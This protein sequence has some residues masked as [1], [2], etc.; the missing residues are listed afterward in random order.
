MQSGSSVNSVARTQEWAVAYHGTDHC[1][2]PSILSTGL[3]PGS[4]QVYRREVGTGVYVSP[5]MRHAAAYSTAT[6][7]RHN[8]EPQ[9]PVAASTVA[10]RKVGILVLQTFEHRH[11]QLIRELACIAAQGRCGP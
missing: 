7:I 8:G 2:L 10:Q 4:R 3:R 1:N 11:V 6:R 5:Y 9:C